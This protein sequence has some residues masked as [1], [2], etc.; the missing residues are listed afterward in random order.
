V[1]LHLRYAL[2]LVML[3][4]VLQGYGLTE[5]TAVAAYLDGEEESRHYGSV[6]LLTPNTE[7]KIIDPDSGTPLPPNNRGELWLHG[8]IVMKGMCF[9]NIISFIK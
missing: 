2:S 9:L 1:S 7:A 3:Q 5:T 6:G 8:P 4:E